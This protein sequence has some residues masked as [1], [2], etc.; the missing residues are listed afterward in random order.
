MVGLQQLAAPSLSARIFI[1][2]REFIKFGIVGGSGVVVNLLVFLL[3]KKLLDYS[4]SLHEADVFFNLLN[5]RFNVRWYHVMAT[6]AFLLANVW[7]YQLNRSWTFRRIP[8]KPWLKGFLPFLA[9]GLAAFVVSLVFLTLFMNE[10][11]PLSL[12]EHIF[13]GSTGLRTKSYWAQLLSTL[14][15]MP[16]NFLVNKFWAFSK[17]KVPP[18]ET[19]Q[20]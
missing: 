16:V 15:A 2:F 10:T 7:N 19:R 8:Q 4:F 1:G 13:D 18:L 17:P 9:T 3:V 12:P 6:V 5:T 11:S 20:Q 14:I